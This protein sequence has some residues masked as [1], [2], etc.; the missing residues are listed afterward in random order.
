[1]DEVRR[2][3]ERRTTMTLA[4]AAEMLEVSEERAVLLARK[5]LVRASEQQGGWHIDTLSV[6]GYLSEKVLGGSRRAG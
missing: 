3:I 4:E 6:T 2:E 1:V 5:G